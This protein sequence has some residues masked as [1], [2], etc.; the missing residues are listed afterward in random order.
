MFGS[1]ACPLVKAFL[2]RLKSHFRRGDAIKRAYCSLYN[3]DG[4]EIRPNVH[5][6]VKA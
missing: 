1:Y 4:W 5:V 2:W 3:K 6:T